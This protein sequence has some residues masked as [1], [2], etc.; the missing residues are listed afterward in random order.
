MQQ[1]PLV[2][3]SVVVSESAVLVEVLP[4]GGAS[5]ASGLAVFPALDVV[6]AAVG[7]LARFVRRRRGRADLVVRVRLEGRTLWERS[8]QGRQAA[9]ECV[10]TV[11]QAL[12]RGGL[13]ALE[14]LPARRTGR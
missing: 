7:G 13:A 3:R 1:E 5:A 10:Q 2:S 8:V 4:A 6:V 14:D 11:E 12:R 9:D